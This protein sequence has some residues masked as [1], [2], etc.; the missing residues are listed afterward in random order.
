MQFHRINKIVL[1]LILLSWN[2]LAAQ[3]ETRPYFPIK[4]AKDSYA[5]ESRRSA[6]FEN[7]YF[8]IQSIQIELDAVPRSTYVYSG[9]LSPRLVDQ[10]YFDNLSRPEPSSD[11]QFVCDAMWQY[12]WIQVRLFTDTWPGFKDIRTGAYNYKNS[13][14][15]GGYLISAQDS[16]VF[17]SEGNGIN[18]IPYT[19]IRNIRRGQSFGTIASNIISSSLNSSLN[20]GLE[21]FLTGIVVIPFAALFYNVA[22]LLPHKVVRMYGEPRGKE[23]A[24]KVQRQGAY[25]NSSYPASDYPL[26]LIQLN[27]RSFEIAPRNIFPQ[28]NFDSLELIADKIQLKEVPH[29]QDIQSII[30]NSQ[31]QKTPISALS[32]NA[33]SNDPSIES[34]IVK[35]PAAIA[36]PVNKPTPTKVIQVNAFNNANGEVPIDWAIEKFEPG[37]VSSKLFKNYPR[38]QKEIL[39]QSQL[40]QL[41][42][43]ADIQ[44]LAILLLTGNGL[45]FSRLIQFTEEQTYKL[46]KTITVDAVYAEMGSM[47]RVIDIPSMEYGNLTLLYARLNQMMKK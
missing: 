4:R 26:T 44:M 37:N 32:K 15:Y 11:G 34:S 12:K 40:D 38:I 22:G 14:Q 17:V 42:N 7:G 16:G 25:G 8:Q 45:D 36:S 27:R 29:F 47:L 43:P 24:S 20:Q 21:G 41:T 39:T 13:D 6:Y 5:Y 19:Y 31:I 3:F 2:T 28:E 1:L 18:Y 30:A 46:N 35:A 9:K 23:F 33:Q 10:S